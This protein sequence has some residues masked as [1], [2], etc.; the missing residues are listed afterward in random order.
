MPVHGLCRNGKNPVPSCN[1][2]LNWLIIA[3][4]VRLRKA[5]LPDLSLSPLAK[6]RHQ[7]DELN[8]TNCFYICELHT[9]HK[10]NSSVVCILCNVR[11]IEK[12]LEILIS[13]DT[14]SWILSDL[15]H[16]PPGIVVN[17]IL[18]QCVIGHRSKSFARKIILAYYKLKSKL[19]PTAITHAAFRV[20]IC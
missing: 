19:N 11:L 15:E 6:N 18:H 3:F 7:P 20:L 10:N 13:L 1:R 14:E 9:F 5:T 2:S 16:C 12:I 17:V 4:S 8:G